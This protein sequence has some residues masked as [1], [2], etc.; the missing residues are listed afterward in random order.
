MCYDFSTMFSFLQDPNVQRSL[1]VREGRDWTMCNQTVYLPF[2]QSGDWFKRSD[3]DVETL[4]SAGIPVLV[5]NG[6]ADGMVDWVGSKAWATELD[7]A[8]HAQWVASPDVPFT[9]AGRE[10]GLYRSVHGFTFLQVFEAGHMVPLD[11]PEAALALLREFISVNS[12]WH[13]RQTVSS[14]AIRR[15]IT[16]PLSSPDSLLA[17]APHVLSA[18]VAALVAP[19]AV[20]AAM[21][22][23]FAVGLAVWR[24]PSI[25]GND[26]RES[27]APLS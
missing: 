26:V 16:P 4:L 10:A 9:V 24:M 21:A 3:F 1:G 15:P 25:S 17:A 2:V 12:R 7:W 27:Y 14:V 23:L 5:Y 13:R 20:V 22:A 11:Q 19:A 6:D 8:H 18:P